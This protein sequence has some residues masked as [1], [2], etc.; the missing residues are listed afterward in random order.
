MFNFCGVNRK[1]EDVEFQHDL[2]RCMRT[3]LNNKNAMQAVLAHPSA[4]N[5][6]SLMLASNNL[7]DRRLM[8]EMLSG[9]IVIDKS[10]HEKVIKGALVMFH[11]GGE[12]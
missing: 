6:M 9:I 11:Y 5:I 2:V 1:K 12:N 10:G 3:L 7:S 4:V 8:L